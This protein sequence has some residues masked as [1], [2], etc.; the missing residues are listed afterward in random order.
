ME[1]ESFQIIEEYLL[2]K[3]S[4][5]EK[6]IFEQKLTKDTNLKQEFDIINSIFQ[7]TELSVKE[8][9]KIDL[10]NIHRRNFQTTK[11]PIAKI[12]RISPFYKRAAIV[13]LL[14]CASI[15]LWV[16]S[17][18]NGS[19]PQDQ[20]YA[21]YFEP[22]ELAISYRGNQANRELENLQEL[23]NAKKYRVF[24]SELEDYKMD[25]NDNP[26]LKLAK[27]QAHLELNQFSL[28]ENNFKSLLT[29]PL[30]KDQA[31]WYLGLSYLKQGKSKESLNYLSEITNQNKYGNL[32]KE[33]MEE[34]N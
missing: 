1:K 30:Y 25:E 32:A 34:L 12:V 21:S 7:S 24:I 13:F 27:G 8:K 28:A 31:N 23:F 33:L 16:F 3:M 22:T 19:I 9:M 10:E 20:L 14:I 17:N 2:D 18:Q 5:K 15:S 4:S 29:N 6:E 11:P 26:V